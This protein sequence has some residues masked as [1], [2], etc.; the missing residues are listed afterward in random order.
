MIKSEH[1]LPGNWVK[2]LVDK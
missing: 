2:F 1:I